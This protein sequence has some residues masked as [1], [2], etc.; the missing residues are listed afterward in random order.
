MTN[1]DLSGSA[2]SPGSGSLAMG[3]QFFAV[4]VARINVFGQPAAAQ[5][6]KE[7]N[8]AVLFARMP[9]RPVKRLAIAVIEDAQSRRSLKPIGRLRLSRRRLH[10][11][12]K[13]K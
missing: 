13:V 11:V 7:R 4:W 9:V 2:N 8:T 10:G 12:D 6:Q 1:R 3:L 5:C